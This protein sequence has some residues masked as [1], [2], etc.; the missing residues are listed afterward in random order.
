MALRPEGGVR[1]GPLRPGP[2]LPIRLAIVYTVQHDQA[3]S[4]VVVTQTNTDLLC[5]CILELQK[6]FWFQ[7]LSNA[8]E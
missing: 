7:I 3:Q 4:H 8:L 6:L 2:T 5:E 1:A